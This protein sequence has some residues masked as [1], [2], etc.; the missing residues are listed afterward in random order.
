MNKPLTI[1]FLLTMLVLISN[2]QK[3]PNI[4]TLSVRTPQQLIIDGNPKEWDNNLQAHNHATEISY[5]IANDDNNLYLVAQ[6]TDQDV[7]NKI[8]RGGLTL[9]IQKTGK[10]DDKNT[11]AIT[12]PISDI[13]F[14]FRLRVLKEGKPDTTTEVN[15]A[16]MGKNNKLLE[17]HIKSIGIK[18]IGGIDSLISIY[19]ENDIKAAGLFDFNKVYTLELCLPLKYLQLSVAVESK[20]S[21]HIILNGYKRAPTIGAPIKMDGTPVTGPK[22]ESMMAFVAQWDAAVSARTDFWGEYTLAKK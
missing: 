4:Q 13:A 3:L 22:V 7:I 12:Y 14:S 5:T 20:F 9:A 1:T 15:N 11:V 21:Y 8:L 10:K 18:G 17:Q 6:A 16:L 19:N 2:A